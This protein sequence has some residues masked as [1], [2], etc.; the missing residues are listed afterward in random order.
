ML[1]FLSFSKKSQFCTFFE[2]NVRGIPNMFT[3]YIYMLVWADGRPSFL[4]SYP[5]L[6]VYLAPNFVYRQH[7]VENIKL[8][9]AFLG[10]QNNVRGTT[11][12]F[13]FNLS[14]E[15][16]P[17]K[18]EKKREK[19]LFWEVFMSK[20]PY[21]KCKRSSLKLQ[22]R[23]LHFSHQQLRPLPNIGNSNGGYVCAEKEK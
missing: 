13:I 21:F 12:D 19:S 2:G 17:E 9:S 4:I 7:A 8:L 18:N 11:T 1:Q 20:E 6:Y 23:S 14:L 10:N 16:R 15:R 22:N 5:T 3:L